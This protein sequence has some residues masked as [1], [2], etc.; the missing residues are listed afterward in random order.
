MFK[1]WSSQI[2]DY[3]IVICCFSTEHIASRSKNKDWLTRNQ[4]SVL[5]WTNMSFCNSEFFPPVYS[6]L[7][8][9]R[10]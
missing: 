10:H 6:F 1:P 3:E 8:D 9:K 5:D 7:L 2:K 4:D